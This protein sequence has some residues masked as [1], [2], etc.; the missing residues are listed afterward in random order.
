[1]LDVH[2]PHAPT[3]TWRDFLIHIATIVIGLLIAVGL[4]QTVEYFHHR[5]QVSEA[6]EAL[7]AERVLNLHRFQLENEILHTKSGL[8]QTDAEVYAFLRTHPHAPRSSW[9]GEINL[10]GALVT[11]NNS[12]WKTAQQSGVLTYMPQNEVKRLDELY[13]RL[14]QINDV[15]L[16]IRVAD[17]D[18]RAIYLAGNPADLEPDDWTKA[19][20]ALDQLRIKYAI[21]AQLQRNVATRFPDFPV[22]ATPDDRSNFMQEPDVPTQ[23]ALW[24]NQMDRLAAID[25]QYEPR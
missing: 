1:M 5:H 10:F 22:T 15:Q 8:L 14:D 16:E 9:P 23:H 11:Y 25:A 21:V 7:R 3:H 17:F 2:P 24:Q 4:E 13:Q 18:A 12:A 20:A 19:K 6:R